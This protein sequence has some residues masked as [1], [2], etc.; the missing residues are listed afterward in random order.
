MINLKYF[1]IETVDENTFHQLLNLFPVNFHAEICK[2]VFLEDKVRCL[3]G[4]TMVFSAY[5]EDGYTSADFVANWYRDKNNKPHITGWKAFNISHSGKYVVYAE[6]SENTLFGIDI[7]WIDRNIEIEEL[8]AFFCQ[9]EQDFILGHQQGRSDAFFNVW[10]RKEALLKASGI[11]I[12]DGLNQCNCLRSDFH[13]R[14]HEWTIFSPDFHDPD[15]KLH[16][17]YSTDNVSHIP[18][19]VTEFLIGAK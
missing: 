9:E 11:G 8:T 5:L 3:L 13:W 10:T 18:V 15:Y 19:A 12:V 4:K 16:I 14:S 1:D 17:A 7:E 6:T 2:Y